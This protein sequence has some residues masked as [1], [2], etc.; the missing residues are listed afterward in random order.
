MLTEKKYYGILY[1]TLKAVLPM[2][3]RMPVINQSIPQG[4]LFFYIAG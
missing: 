1:V 2:A 3:V 4:G